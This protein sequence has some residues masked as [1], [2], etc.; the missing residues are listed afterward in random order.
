[1]ATVAQVVDYELPPNAAEDSLSLMPLLRG[2]RLDKPLHAAVVCHSISGHFAL[3][4][5]Q[6]KVMWCRGSG[7]WSAPRESAAAK[8]K[9]PAIQLYNLERDPRETTNV[10]DSFPQVVNT[11]KAILRSYV[12]QGRST[13]GTPQ[14]NFDG[15]T[16]WGHLP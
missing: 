1:M 9:L 4:S 11:L 16:D 14:K 5:G 2:A 8:Q 12:D 15:G 7:G 10:A 13:P 6:W 3:R